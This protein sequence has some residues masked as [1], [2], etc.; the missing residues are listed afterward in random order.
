M[1]NNSYRESWIKMATHVSAVALCAGFMLGNFASRAASPSELLEK[2]VYSEESKGDLDAAMQLYQQVIKESK[3]Q[4]SVAA[5]AQYRLAVCYYKKKDYQK[6]NEAFE[7]LVKDYPDQ[8]ELVAKATEYLSGASSFLPAP[9]VDG[10]TMRYDLKM[11]GGVRIGV[12]TYAV[13]SGQLSGKP[14]WRFSTQL[15]AAGLQQVSKVEVGL[16]SLKPIHSRWKHTLLGDA[17][18]TYD[19]TTATIKL[20]GKEGTKKI[21]LKGLIYDNEEAVQLLRC[22]P[23]TTNYETSLTL[24]SSLAGGAIVPLKVTIEG[25]ESLAVPAGTMEC[26][27]VELSIHQTFWFSTDAHHYLVKFEAG[28]VV[29]E[30]T[31]I[32]VAKANE[33]ETITDPTYHYTLSAPKGWL[34]DRHEPDN[35]SEP[36]SIVVLDPDASGT[37]VFQMEKK[38]NLKET[39][40]VSLRAWADSKAGEAA[41]TFKNF[42]VRPDSWFSVQLAG[43]PA[44][45]FTAD[46][47]EQGKPKV[48]YALFAFDGPNAVSL[49]SYAPA[50]E[51]DH[52]QKGLA[53]VIKS[54]AR[55]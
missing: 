47:S 26:F 52:F 50:E 15:S 44:I 54:C 35:S 24:L 23:L 41:K 49:V 3:D 11:A 4:Q 30:L 10:E 9:W 6:S 20:K 29:A 22:L 48:A 12:A 2:G 37:A 43:Q 33:P 51:F 8:K 1:K 34:F 55:K 42:K 17:D 13:E 16:D 46:L 32:K 39:A 21:D 25:V 7:K 38:E 45:R 18:T 14:M 5:Q 28:G 53:S 36:T 40:K 31:S 19:G 27:K